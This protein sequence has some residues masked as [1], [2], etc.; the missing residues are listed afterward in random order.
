[1]ARVVKETDRVL[2]CIPELFGVVMNREQDLFTRSILQWRQHLEA[3]LGER[4]AHLATSLCGF[5]Q[6]ADASGIVLVADYSAMRFWANATDGSTINAI[7]A[8]VTRTI[9][10]R[11]LMNPSNYRTVG[12]C[13]EADRASEVS[14]ILRPA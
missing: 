14:K 11:P 4:R 10:Q 6:R 2:A 5:F 3:N 7:K 1:M 8:M 12:D 13:G 9:L